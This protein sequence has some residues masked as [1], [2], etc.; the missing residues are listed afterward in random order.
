MKRF[1]MALAGEAITR[2]NRLVM[3]ACIVITIAAAWLA[4]TGLRF[5]GDVAD[6]L[7][8]DTPDYAKLSSMQERFHSFS[9]DEVVVVSADDLGDTDTFAAFE[10]FV[11]ELQLIP[12]VS[13]VVSVFTVPGSGDGPFLSGPQI[14][15]M[16]PADRLDRLLASQPLATSIL[17]ADRTT[18]VVILMA[19]QSADGQEQPLT[20][21]ARGE[22]AEIA[23]FYAPLVQVQTAGIGAIH[24]TLE[25]TLMQD[26]RLLTAISTILCVVLSLVVYRSWRG[27]IIC[28][29]PPMLGAIWFLGFAAFA[30][31]TIDTVTT[32]IPTLLI[33]VG[34][35]D[36]VHLYYSLT[37]ARSNGYKGAEAVKHAMAETAPACFLT[38]LTTGLACLGI[39]LSGTAVL[40]SFAIAGFVGMLIELTAVLLAFPVLAL[41]FDPGEKERHEKIA[42]RFAGLGGAATR[43]IR[44]RPVVVALSSALLVFLWFAQFNLQPGFSLSEHL[45][46]DGALRQVEKRLAE[47]GLGSGQIFVV[48]DDA[49]GRAGHQ[50]ADS[51]H[52]ALVAEAAFPGARRT[53]T[54]VFPSA[55][56]IEQL[57]AENHPLLRRYVSR[58][59]LAYLL[60]IPVNLSARSTDILERAGAIGD[61]LEAGG[62]AGKYEIVGL[63][64]LSATEVP[65][66]INDLRTGFYVAL[67]LIVGVLIYATGS[68]WLGL[69]SLV[70]NLIPVLGVEAWL[71]ITGQLLSM[72]AAIALTI[73]FGIAVDNSIH[74]LNRYQRAHTDGVAPAAPVAIRDT[75]SPMTASTLIL[76]AGL[77]VTQLSSL[78]SVAIF[79]QMVAAALVLAL[80]ANL[81]VMPS[82]LDRNNR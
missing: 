65:R 33:V 48:I 55:A 71:W 5:N 62:L 18:T 53:A 38:S 40:N 14:R 51:K 12:G 42:F 28:G 9:T 66:M 26:Q 7:K 52:M 45:P 74:F 56:Q 43:L 32:V 70:P 81:F 34:F 67:V 25:Q 39:G 44:M 2:R 60:P 69:L 64:L 75:V 80:F 54:E 6:V 68:V 19:A 10:E 37:R 59:G 78:P 22:I 58:D 1:G 4:A 76:V 11:S 72:T 57:T 47:K 15:A 35:S 49:D 63:P 46:A 3:A 21:A 16:E 73:A 20:D 17:S 79:G 23:E 50:D 41:I 8:A 30:G 29:I 82:F 24:R 36:S 77:G 13:A 61:R 31:I 27:S